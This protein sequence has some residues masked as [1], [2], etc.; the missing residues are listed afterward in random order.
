MAATVSRDAFLLGIR[1][2]AVVDTGQ[3]DALMQR[4]EISGAVPENANALADVLVREGI[5]TRFQSEQFLANRWTGLTLGKY[6]VL[7]RLGRG[8]N[9]SV[10]LCRHQ[11]MGRTVAIKVLPP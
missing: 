6:Q 2:A 4:L 10:Y 9:G 1:R 11:A 3:L 8:A 5:L 7:E